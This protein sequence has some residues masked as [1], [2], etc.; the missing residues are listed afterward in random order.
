MDRT[1]CQARV[2]RT[3]GAKAAIHTVSVT[4]IAIARGPTSKKSF[5]D[6]FMPRP[7]MAITNAH[8][9]ASARAVEACAGISADT[10]DDHKQYETDQEKRKSGA[11][12]RSQTGHGKGDGGDHGHQHGDAQQLDDG[13]RVAGLLRD[14]VAG[15]DHLGDIVHSRPDE[16]AGRPVIE[17]KK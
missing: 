15:A 13:C 16:D 2:E 4:M 7:A 3:I 12:T 6:V 9:D 8:R 17:A 11:R 14:R 10:V 1:C 5:S